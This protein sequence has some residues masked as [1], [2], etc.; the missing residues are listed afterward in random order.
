MEKLFEQLDAP[1]PEL[2]IEP[3]LL[4]QQREAERNGREWTLVQTNILAVI[5]EGINPRILI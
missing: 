3:E 2:Q 1:M 4:E 5:G